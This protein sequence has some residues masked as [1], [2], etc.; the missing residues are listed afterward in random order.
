MNE[1][2]NKVDQSG[3][4]TIDPEDFLR[5]KPCIEFDIAPWLFENV[6]LREKDFREHIKTHDWKQYEKKYVAIFCSADA[7]IPTWAYMLV[8]SALQP[9][10]SLTVFGSLS[11][12]REQIFYHALQQLNAEKFSGSRIVIKG[13]SEGELPVAA[14]IALV[15]A[16]QPF[17]KSIMYGEPCSTVPVYKQKAQQ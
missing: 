12:L 14:Y 8:A 5:D 11:H 3:I 15:N 6:M 7:I 4:V 9:Y 13:C 17:A 2:I 10:S 16:L 1:I